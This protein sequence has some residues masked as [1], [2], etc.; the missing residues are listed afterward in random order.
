MAV[1][2]VTIRGV[3]Y[4]QA[5]RRGDLRAPGQW[6]KAV[7]EQTRGL[8]TVAEACFVKVTFLLPANKF[9]TDFPYGPDLDNLLKRTLDALQTTIF[10]KA[11]GRDSCVV[12]LFAMKTKV[13]DPRE[14]GAH[15]EV[16]PVTV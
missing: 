4:A 11:R 5:K 10:R 9:P 14:A 12:A 15:L 7:V 2:G 3:P 6:T 1:I 8:P 13:D 16:L